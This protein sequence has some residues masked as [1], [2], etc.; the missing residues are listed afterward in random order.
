MPRTETNGPA[1]HRRKATLLD[2]VA[3]GLGSPCLA[4]VFVLYVFTTWAPPAWPRRELLCGSLLLIAAGAHLITLPRAT[5]RMRR[6]GAAAMAAGL[7]AVLAA[8]RW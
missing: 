3:H 4:A 7:A 1:P 2:V 5:P 8:G 6:V